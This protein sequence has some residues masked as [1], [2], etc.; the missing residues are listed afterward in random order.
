MFA[1]NNKQMNKL[2]K[3][4]LSPL[5]LLKLMIV[6]QLVLIF[7]MLE[8]VLQIFHFLINTPLRWALNKIEKLIKYLI[9]QL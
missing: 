4:I 3:F 2:V 8:S 5:N 1:S 7:W 9:K 6:I